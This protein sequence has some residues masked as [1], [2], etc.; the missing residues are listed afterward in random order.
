MDRQW[1]LILPQHTDKNA[2]YGM[3]VEAGKGTGC[4]IDKLDH[5]GL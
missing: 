2:F 1:T 3:Y 4:W 5:V